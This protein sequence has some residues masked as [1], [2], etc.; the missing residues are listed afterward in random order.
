MSNS[1]KNQPS[2]LKMGR[3]ASVFTWTSPCVSVFPSLLSLRRMLVIG[4]KFTQIIQDD[5]KILN[6]ICKD[7]SFIVRG[8]G[9]LGHGCIGLGTTIQF[10]T[11]PHFLPWTQILDL[12]KDS[13]WPKFA[14]APVSN[15]LSESSNLGFSGSF[16]V[17]SSFSKK[18]VKSG[19]PESPLP[20]IFPLNNFPPTVPTPTLLLGCK[21]SS[22]IQN[23]AHFYTVVSFPLL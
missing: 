3:A 4:F 12:D 19:E 6:Y 5:F 16:P 15:F 7:S 23:W 1:N 13:L 21:Y 11:L 18:P 9:V 17:E 20:L 2:D 14:Q 22:C 10:P 8:S